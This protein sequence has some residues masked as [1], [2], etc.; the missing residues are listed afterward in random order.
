MIILLAEI[1]SHPS[2]LPRELFDLRTK[3]KNSEI[4]Q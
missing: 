4:L 3:L 1:K 2:D